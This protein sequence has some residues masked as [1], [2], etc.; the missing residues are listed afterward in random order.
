MVGEKN[1]LATGVV[2]V[3]E[4]NT[5]V[6]VDGESGGFPDDAVEGGVVDGEFDKEVEVGAFD[7]AADRAEYH[8]ETVLE[9]ES[10]GEGAGMDGEGVVLL[11]L[12]DDVEAATDKGGEGPS[13]AVDEAE[14]VMEEQAEVGGRH[15]EVEVAVGGSHRVAQ[16]SGAAVTRG[17]TA[18]RADGG[19]KRQAALWA[20]SLSSH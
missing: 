15:I 13:V 4:G 18:P 17:S 2:A 12:V 9:E 3:A 7:T 20:G 8:G 19:E 5:Q 1:P 16:R 10:S 6:E 14:A 11:A